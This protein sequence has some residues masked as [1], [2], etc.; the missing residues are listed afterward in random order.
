VVLVIGGGGR[1]FGRRA[2][3]LPRQLAGVAPLHHPW[4]LA[5][6]WTNAIRIHRSHGAFAA[7]VAGTLWCAYGLITPE[8]APRYWDVQRG[9]EYIA[10]SCTG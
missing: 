5:N 1:H 10:V 3:E 2:R 6:A 8:F 4:R 9:G 7:L